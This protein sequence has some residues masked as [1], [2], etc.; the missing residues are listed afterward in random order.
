MA[1]PTRSLPPLATLRVFDAVARHASFTR[2]ADELAITQAAVSRQIKR[3][4]E[5]LGAALFVRGHRSIAITPAGRKLQRAARQAF[6][7]IAAATE[8]IAADRRARRLSISVSPFFS[9]AWLTPRLPGFQRKHPD[10]RVELHHAYAPPD[11]HRAD[12]DLGINWGRGRWPGIVAEK[13]LDGAL[14]PMLAPALRRARRIKAPADLLRL[15]L[16]Y[17]FDEADWRAWFAAAGVAAPERLHLRRIDDSHALQQA[18]LDGQGVALFFVALAPPD[19][20]A[21][22]LEQPFA[23]ALADGRDY[24]L[25]YPRRSARA[26]GLRMFRQ[27]LLSEMRSIKPTLRGRPS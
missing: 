24:Y 17:E 13:V 14:A 23:T 11:Y 15:P 3:L 18:A 20:A 8:A 10:L 4:E 2:A 21:G 16:L 22:R 7:A 25:N 1:S 27:W 12:I 9:A 6:A 19:L 26:A 5:D